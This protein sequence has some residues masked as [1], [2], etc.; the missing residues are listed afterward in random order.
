MK[1]IQKIILV[2]IVLLFSLLLLT[3]VNTTCKELFGRNIKE[4]RL[5]GKYY[6]SHD[7]GRTWSEIQ[8]FNPYRIIEEKRLNGRYY[9]SIDYGVT[10]IEFQKN[11][12][13]EP[14]VQSSLASNILLLNSQFDK[15]IMYSFTQLK[16]QN[17]DIYVYDILG[18]CVFKSRELALT[19]RTYT[20]S[21]QFLPKGIYFFQI[22]YSE[23]RRFECLRIIF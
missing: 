16:A 11:S 13:G 3:S 7:Y 19:N 23:D 21:L 1:K 15:T 14:K 18:N 5:N 12:I 10:W 17:I 22:Y 8:T 9:L 2:S 4:K 20:H 6:S